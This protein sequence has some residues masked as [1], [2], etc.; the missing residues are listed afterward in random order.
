MRPQWVEELPQ[1]RAEAEYAQARR[2]YQYERELG[3]WET[4]Q[5]REKGK[6][7]EWEAKFA[8]IESQR[9]FERKQVEPTESAY[10]GKLKRREEIAAKLIASRTL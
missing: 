8:T 4:K 1:E 5:A 9:Q 6:A 2:Q 7:A 10:A 3:A